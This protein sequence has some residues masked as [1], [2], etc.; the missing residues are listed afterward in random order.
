MSSSLHFVPVRCWINFP[1]T[2]GPVYGYPEYQSHPTPMAPVPVTGHP[3]A[4]VNGYHGPPAAPA[5]FLPPGVPG[6]GHSHHSP[7]GSSSTCTL[8]QIPTTILELAGQA[9]YN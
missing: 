6:Q 9:V 1:N 8:R 4:P 3:Y 2:L 5:P 7:A